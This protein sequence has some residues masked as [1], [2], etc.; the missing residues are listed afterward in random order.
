VT[1]P[2]Q[3]HAVRRLRH[4]LVAVSLCFGLGLALLLTK[5]PAVDELR[6]GVLAPLSDTSLRMSVTV[7][8]LNDMASRINAAGGVDV[9]GKHFLLRLVVRDTGN[10]VETAMSEVNLLIRQE[11]I[12]AI[13]GPYFSRIALPVAQVAEAVHVPM[14]TPTASVPELTQGRRYVFRACLTNAAQAQAMAAFAV[15]E[16]HQRRAAVL[17]DAADPYSG[18]L[19]S[20]FR[21]AFARQGGE[22]VECMYTTGQTSFYG[23]IQNVL[24][25]RAGVLYLPNFPKDVSRQMH[26]AREAGF[27]GVFLGADG[28]ASDLH[29]ANQPEA[30]G[31]FFTADYAPD[32]LSPAAEAESKGYAVRLGEPLDKEASLSIDAL[33]MLLAAVR[34]A[35]AVDPVAIR[36][37]LAAVQGYEGITGRISFHGTGDAE[38]DVHILGIA[39]GAA[40]LRQI[41]LSRASQ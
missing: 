5:K 7:R 29:F 6:I 38:R 1:A 19:A 14:L 32:G 13:I 18:G 16:L 22:V 9:G 2:G 21:H 27:R 4:I 8:A 28:W 15:D 11:R 26:E 36:D 34:S 25:N 23:Q 12:S 24:K 35:E 33:G 10:R 40:H 30:Q 17:Y 20:Q 3:N 41:S 39:G 37:A 31:S